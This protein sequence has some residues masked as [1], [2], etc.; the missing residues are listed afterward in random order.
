[1]LMTLWVLWASRGS[2][3]PEQSDTDQESA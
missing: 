3:E 1:V 2:G